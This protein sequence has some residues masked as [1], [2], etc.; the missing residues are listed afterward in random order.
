MTEIVSGVLKLTFGI[1]ANKARSKISERLQ[2][3]DVSHEE[4]RRLIVRELDD[5]KKKLDG[6]ARKDL[7]SSLL[8]LQD[9]VDRLYQ[10]IIQFQSSEHNTAK[11]TKVDPADSLVRADSSSDTGSDPI[12]NAIALL[13][14]V[15][16]LKIHSNK[17]FTSAMESFKLAYEKATEAFANDDLSIEDRIQASQVRIMARILENLEDPDA[18][19]SD[20]L[21]YLKQLHDIGAIEATFSIL[22]QGGIASWRNEAKRLNIASSV[23]LMNQLSYDFIRK[24]TGSRPVMFDWPLILFGN[25]IYHPLFGDI[26]VLSRLSVYGV[27]AMSLDRDLIFDDLIS[28]HCSAVNSKREIIGMGT[29][30]AEKGSITIFKSSGE[31]R[32]F[33]EFPKNYQIITMDIDAEGNLY[34]IALRKCSVFAEPYRYILFIFAENGESK[35]EYSRLFSARSR[36]DISPVPIA[37]N[38]EKII[39]LFDTKHKKVQFGDTRCADFCFNREIYLTGTLSKKVFLR[40]VN[41]KLI[42]ANSLNTVNVYTVDGELQCKFRIRKQYGMIDSVAINYVTKHILFKTYANDQLFSFTETGELVASVC[43]GKSKWIRD[44]VVASHPNGTLALVGETE[45]AFLQLNDG[46]C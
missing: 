46:K 18:S 26:R 41:T 5:I 37:I 36:R 39:A 31:S 38:E 33:C 42:V 8:F 13:N 6:L 25:K 9:G 45:A 24:F 30:A 28:P 12:K 32:S 2:D 40:F 7:Q 14:T 27:K 43:L 29:R 16:A 15:K 20:C 3:S 11:S 34:L 44:A 4:C 19:V 22:I 21:K 35:L 1:L 10:S 23:V 17:R